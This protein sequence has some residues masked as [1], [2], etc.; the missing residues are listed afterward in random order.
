MARMQ[1]LA[2][3]VARGAATAILAAALMPLT[4]LAQPWAPGQGPPPGLQLPSAEEA[5]QLEQLRQQGEA[6][7]LRQLYLRSAHQ[8]L[9]RFWNS[10]EQPKLLFAGDKAEGCGVKQV[11]HPMAYYCPP[12]KELAIALNLRR[13]VSSA[14][15]K[16]GATT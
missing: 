7:G 11:A 15:G 16:S 10:R 6:E 12:S 5:K 1:I 14:K 9:H 3:R 4:A 13:S 2:G 8:L